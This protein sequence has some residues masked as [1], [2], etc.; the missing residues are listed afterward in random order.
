MNLQGRKELLNEFSASDLETRSFD[1]VDPIE[2]PLRDLA[3]DLDFYE[4]GPSSFEPRIPCIT[5]K[6]GFKERS[7]RS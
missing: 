6:S 5:V 2:Q 1:C 4:Q 3:Y 7:R